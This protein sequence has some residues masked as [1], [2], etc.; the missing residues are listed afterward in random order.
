[1]H[2]L[3][4]LLLPLFVLTVSSAPF[5]LTGTVV[6]QAPLV[7]ETSELTIPPIAPLDPR[8]T[9]DWTDVDPV[10]LDQKSFIAA[11]TDVMAKLAARD[12]NGQIGNFQSPLIPD[13][14]GVIIRFRVHGPA[15]QVETRFA[16]W[17]VYLLV[18]VLAIRNE[19]QSTGMKLLWNNVPIATLTVR[20]RS[21][22]SSPLTLEQ[23]SDIPQNSSDNM[24][25]LTFPTGFPAAETNKYLGNA[26]MTNQPTGNSLDALCRFFDDY[27]VLSTSEVLGPLAAGFR[28]VA[29]V[30]KTDR[31][32]G[33][34]ST[35][36]EGIDTE[37]I[38]GGG[39]TD[40]NHP[41]YQYVYV[42]KTLS[43]MS[44]WQLAQQ[45]FGEMLCWMAIDRRLDGTATL[46][47]LSRPT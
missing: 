47:K 33:I 44:R 3:K 7:N 21:T 16:V 31:M 18:S 40:L 27:A 32:D 41:T 6:Y 13:F 20:R 1:M 29:V 2:P 42:I 26:N 36:T 45:R 4:I 17:G 24:P 14:P 15:Q 8:F 35:F 37:V 34:L 30:P 38:F 19:Y 39:D 11:A 5:N 25:F 23:R 12:N 28:N 9:Y 43:A 10:P 46:Q 22:V